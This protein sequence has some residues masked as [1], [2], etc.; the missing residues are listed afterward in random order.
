[1]IK[2]TCLKCEEAVVEF[3]VEDKLESCPKCGAEFTSE[4]L[5]PCQECDGT[6]GFAEYGDGKE[7]DCGYCRASGWVPYDYNYDDLLTEE[8][9]KGIKGDIEYHYLKDEG[10]I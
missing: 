1:M 6:G 8:D 7:W 9:I 10:L 3:E 5:V 2:I 4:G